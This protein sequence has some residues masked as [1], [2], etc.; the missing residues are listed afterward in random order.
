MSQELTDAIVELNRD[1]AVAAVERRAK[2]GEDPLVIL[3]EC[4]RGMA[5]VG[6][7]FQKGDYFLA[8]L[9]LS[10]EIFKA[11]VAILQ[12]Y[13]ARS[14]SA[15]SKGKVLLATLKGDIHDLGKNIL[16][17]LLQSH[18]FEVHDMGVDIPPSRVVEEAREI[19]PDFVGF[20]A[21]ITTAFAGMKEAADMLQEDGLR[22]NMKLIIGGGVTTPT[23]RDYVGADFQ[24]LDAMEGVTYCLRTV[25][26]E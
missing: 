25:R 17:T 10:A 24:T 3:G 13:L 18:G 1:E 14:R 4:R 19:K 16:A 6:E 5:V 8:E 7:R 23:T 21:L 26:G 11:G 22:H 15:E 2:G 12:P 9:M 20:S